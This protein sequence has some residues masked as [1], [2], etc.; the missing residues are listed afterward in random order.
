MNESDADRILRRLNRIEEGLSDLGKRIASLEGNAV[1]SEVPEPEAVVVPPPV[2]SFDLSPYAPARKSVWEPTETVE[3]PPVPTVAP[4][5]PKPR[6]ELDDLEYKIGLTG[7]L[8]GGAIVVVLGMLFLVALAITRG[9]ITLQMQWAGE[10]ALC[11]A[12]IGVG[13][14][15]RSEREEFGQLMT[16]IGSCGLYLSFAGA[17]VYKELITGE[18]LVLAFVLLSMANLGFAFWKSARS[19]LAIGMIGGLVAAV[20]PMREGKVT[21]DVTLHL[22][23]L[24][25]TTA[26]IV[27]NKWQELA[28]AMWI[29][30]GLALIPVFDAEG[31]EWIV[32]L[33]GI[34]GSTALA[35]AAYAFSFKD[36]DTLMRPFD[37]YAAFLPVCAAVGAAAGVALDRAGH[38]SL[39][40][41]AISAACAGL[42]LASANLTVK[43]MLWLSAAGVAVVFAPMGFSRVEA[44]FAY[45]VLAVAVG[46]LG[47]GLARTRAESAGPRGIGLATSALSWIAFVLA[48]GGYTAF[49]RLNPPPFAPEIP[50]L[51]TAMAAAATSAWAS[52]KAGGTAEYSTL[53]ASL[54]IL[55]LFARTGYVTLLP[56]GSSTALSLLASFLIYAVA[57]LSLGAKTK[58]VSTLVLGWF[59]LIFSM[60]AYQPIALEMP[61]SAAQESGLVA[62]LIAATVYAG[63]ATYQRTQSRD[64]DFLIGGAGAL[65]AL[66]LVRLAIIDFARPHGQLT[67]TAAIAVGLLGVSFL[68]NGLAL[69][70]RWR[71]AAVL[72][73]PAA[74]TGACCAFVIGDVAEPGMKLE[75]PL[76]IASHAAILASGFA[77]W[78]RLEKTDLNLVT[79]I[80]GALVSALLVRLTFVVLAAP[81]GVLRPTSALACGL[82][83]VA[84]GAVGLALGAQWRSMSILAMIAALGA[85]CA[86]F[87][88]PDLLEPGASIDIPLLAVSHLAILCAALA[89]GRFTS[90][91]SA[92]LSYCTLTLLML[93]SRLMDI[94]LTRP[95]IDMKPTAALTLAWILY[96]TTLMVLGFRYRARVLRYW[97]LGLFG[98]TLVKVMVLDLANLDAGIRVI[99]LMALG[100]AM[101]GGG[102][103]YIR[104]RSALT[105]PEGEA[106]TQEP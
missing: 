81:D 93:F 98:L 47:T 44:S 21:L 106:G 24:V 100:L 57:L 95:P 87:V 22:L 72:A 33:I 11:A 15:K 51:L 48:L 13:F 32:K 66:L 49:W 104:L 71:A 68:A 34:Y 94:V 45:A 82:L 20:L 5:P 4:A 18:T 89:S 79:G 3:Q 59:V 27:K 61:Y 12:F 83:V 88:A 103:W 54:I 37:R 69:G 31:Q 58:W 97:S 8:R 84:F 23:I 85:A 75:V 56:S 17:H 90:E 65:V 41:L 36:A 91:R 96:A 86:S 42:A 14:W 43:S 10:L 80:T 76:L 7:L 1:A 2:I 92:L 28:V 38:G 26:I 19:F 55:P 64:F 67:M 39:H 30:A 74:L 101:I 25:P 77:S 78:K 9:W 52:W 73:W 16:G 70:A 6:S 35:L 105:A 99:I 40:V 29:A 102:Y 60:A 50:F 46:V 62:A 63:W 53:A